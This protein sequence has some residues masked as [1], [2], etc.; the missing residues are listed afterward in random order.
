MY[1]TDII[2]CKTKTNFFNG[3]YTYNYANKAT[4]IQERMFKIKII[5]TRLTL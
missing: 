2:K 5:T 1:K 3:M 4:H